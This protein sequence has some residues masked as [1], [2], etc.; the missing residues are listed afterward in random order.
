MTHDC[1]DGMFLILLN[2]HI[3]QYQAGCQKQETF[4]CLFARGLRIFT[5]EK[6]N[7]KLQRT[8][9]VKVV[10][11]TGGMSLFNSLIIF[12]GLLLW[13]AQKL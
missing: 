3:P 7:A 9:Y 2:F 12:Q 5:F 13:R 4:K 10:L 11:L 8:D 1:N 6:I